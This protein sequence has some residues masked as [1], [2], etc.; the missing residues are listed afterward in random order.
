MDEVAVNREIP[1]DEALIELLVLWWRYESQ[2]QPVRGYPPECPSTKS[3]RASRQYDDINGTLETDQ[4]GKQAKEIG[5]I[6]ANIPEPERSA[7][8]CLAKNRATGV[9]VWRN[10]RLPADDVE[11][12]RL[13]SR[14]L[15]MFGVMV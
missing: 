3:F 13:V 2:W 15:D 12:A 5:H 4:R 7:L 10:P 8:Y 11:R 1:N 14:A 9:A 6:V